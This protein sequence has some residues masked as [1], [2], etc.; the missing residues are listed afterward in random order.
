MRTGASV[1]TNGA[2]VMLQNDLLSS[3]NGIRKLFMRRCEHIGNGW[4]R[5]IHLFCDILLIEMLQIVQAQ[6]LKFIK[7]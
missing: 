5:N 4:P 1:L 3:E 7:C 2:T 6:R